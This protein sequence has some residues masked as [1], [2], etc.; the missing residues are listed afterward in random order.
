MARILLVEGSEADAM[1]VTAELARLD[2]PVY[3]HHVDKPRLLDRAL[4]DGPWDLV[5]SDYRLPGYSG[6][7]A[8]QRV[9]AKD[10]DIPF[11]L[12]SGV[13]GEQAAI[14]AMRAGASDYVMK[15]DLARL[16]PAVEREL[17]EGA[18]RR[19]HRE[20][21][22]HPQHLARF[23]AA[24]GLANIA[25]FG[26]RL[27]EWIATAR[28]RGHRLAVAVFDV[29]RAKRFNA[30]LGPRALD[31]V[32]RA[33]GGRVVKALPTPAHAARI[34]DDRLAVAIP[35]VANDEEIL[36]T[37]ERCLVQTF[38]DPFE[39]AGETVTISASAGVCVFPADGAS[40]EQLLEKAEV[41]LARAKAAREAYV[42][43]GQQHRQ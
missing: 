5:V 20:A 2:P 15:S 34:G 37:L 31:L 23:D 35:A 16:R 4:S 18:V 38:R 7:A 13:V 30:S 1:L 33:I 41:A 22:A 21:E 26:E 12:V 19:A 32:M 3:V 24:S 11:I 8:L 14:D 40:G 6:L 25:L 29:D 43:Y 28:A 36:R 10:P 39:V 27:T 42:F 9:K 17:R